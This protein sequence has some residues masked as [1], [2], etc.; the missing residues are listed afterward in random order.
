MRTSTFVLGAVLILVG[1]GAF[2]LTS[3]PP[4]LIPLGFGLVV[5]V[6]ALGMG[7]DRWVRTLRLVMIG[8]TFMGMV[9][10]ASSLSKLVEVAAGG[11]VAQPGSIVATS[12][13]G[14]CCLVYVTIGIRWMLASK[15]SL[16]S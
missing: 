2:I 16:E 1:S 7:N 14:I 3:E 11:D 4:T 15:R 9:S 5:V 10:S 13:L 8:L 12:L 6:L